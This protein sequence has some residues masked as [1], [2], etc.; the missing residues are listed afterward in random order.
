MGHGMLDSRDDR[1]TASSMGFGATTTTTRSLG[2]SG[3]EADDDDG[4][5]VVSGY[6][7]LYICF[8]MVPVGAMPKTFGGEYNCLFGDSL[9]EDPH[10]FIASTQ[11]ES[12]DKEAQ[13][14]DMHPFAPTV[15]LVQKI[16]LM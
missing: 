10:C 12:L 5:E 16:M 1:P 11:A 3:V 13:E 8:L 2:V 15:A 7:V 9:W 4:V 6:V 14:E